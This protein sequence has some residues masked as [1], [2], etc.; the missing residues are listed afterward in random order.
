MLPASAFPDLHHLSACSL[1]PALSSSPPDSRNPAP[2]LRTTN[3]ECVHTPGDYAR[4]TMLGSGMRTYPFASFEFYL[5]VALYSAPFEVFP[6][7][8][9]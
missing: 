5:Q 3:T 7:T 4:G 2:G 9:P 1:N 6:G 8:F